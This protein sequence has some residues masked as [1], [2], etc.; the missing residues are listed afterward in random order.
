MSAGISTVNCNDSGWGFELMSRLEQRQE[1]DL[2]R[3]DLNAHYNFCADAAK[4]FGMDISYDPDDLTLRF[5]RKTW[6]WN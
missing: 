1:V 3:F 5:R 4:R 2:V 6:S